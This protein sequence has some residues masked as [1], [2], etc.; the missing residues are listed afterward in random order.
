[1]EWSLAR[2]EGGE[3][4]EEGFECEDV[5]QGEVQEEEGARNDRLWSEE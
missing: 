4:A 5:T 3:E 1:V 2:W